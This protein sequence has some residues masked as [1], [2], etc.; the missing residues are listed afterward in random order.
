MT[1]SISIKLKA[2]FLLIIFGLNMVVGFA[3]AVGIDMG[4]NSGRIKAEALKTDA[5][6]SH[7]KHTDEKGQKHHTKKNKKDDCCDKEDNC[8]KNKVVKITRTDKTV[9]PSTQ[10]LNPVFFT[11]FVSAYFDHNIVHFPQ[12]FTSNRYFVRGHHPPISDIRIA[13]RSFQI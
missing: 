4:Y 10:L 11:E 9:P 3:C 6:A 1:N 5:N 12:I 8:C 7:S 13:I 2:A